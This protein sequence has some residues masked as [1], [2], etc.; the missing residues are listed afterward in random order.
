MKT[1]AFL[2]MIS[3]VVACSNSSGSK[4]V[5]AVMQIAE[6]YVSGQLKSPVREI[7]DNGVVIIEE[8]TKKFYVDPA[9]IFTGT[10]DN[11]HKED[12]II[13]VV[14]YNN[15]YLGLIEH[16]IL[17]NTDGKLLM[18]R[19]IESDMKILGLKDGIITA[20]LP[21]HPRTSPLYNCSE[22]REVVRYIYRYGE[23]VK[24][25]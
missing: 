18:Q 22:C 13:T 10:I 19:S 7:S 9:S 21:T 1:I 4:K 3:V 23:L 24:T 2:F 16:L 8:G 25:E 6:E 12:A 14:S 20:E 5:N 17:V 15:G 11:D